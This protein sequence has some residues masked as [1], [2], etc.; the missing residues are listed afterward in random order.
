MRLFPA[1]GIDGQF[2]AYDGEAKL[3]ARGY[4]DLDEFTGG[5]RFVNE[6]MP[7]QVEDH[8]VRDPAA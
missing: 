3:V 8:A 5:V 4:L 2:V 7:P 6:L 1:V